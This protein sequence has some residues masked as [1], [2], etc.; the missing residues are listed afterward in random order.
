MAKARMLH[1][2]IS[3]SLQV[4]S[5]P[6][7]AQLLFTWTIPHADDEGRLRGEPKYIKGTVVPYKKWSEKIIKDYLNEMRDARLIYYWEQNN[8]WVIEF[9]KWKEYQHIRKDRLEPSKLPSYKSLND[10]HLSTNRQPADNQLAPQANVIQ[11]NSSEVNK[12]E[13]KEEVADKNSS[14]KTDLQGSIANP[15][16]EV[17]SRQGHVAYELW[18]RMD[19]GNF[20]ALSLYTTYQKKVPEHLLFQWA[21]EIEQDKTVKNKGSVFNSKVEKYLSERR[22]NG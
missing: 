11:D 12:S 22:Q 5:L 14:N 7:P 8:E 15:T 3:K 19:K 13:Y 21:S 17:N 1:N 2:K 6:L 9:I 18:K 4:D 10:N 16:A 20:K